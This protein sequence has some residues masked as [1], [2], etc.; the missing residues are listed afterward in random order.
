MTNKEA[1][2]EVLKTKQ[3]MDKEAGLASTAGK[4]VD[5][6]AAS[7]AARLKEVFRKGIAAYKNMGK[8]PVAPAA[9]IPTPAPTPV[10]PKA[11]PKASPATVQAAKVQE[12]A[13]KQAANNE[14]PRRVFNMGMGEEAEQ[15]V[16]D[17]KWAS[18]EEKRARIRELLN[19]NKGKSPSKG[20]IKPAVGAAPRETKDA[21]KTFQPPKIAKDETVT[22]VNKAMVQP[23]PKSRVKK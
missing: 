5:D 21:L 22:P 3:A 7:G 11:L 17:T 10:V 9:P 13:A 14:V 20:D 12:V 16:K 1:L 19:A 4:Y 6:L 18:L 8:A 2:L 23:T 15:A